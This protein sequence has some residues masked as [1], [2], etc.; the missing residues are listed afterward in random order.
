MKNEKTRNYFAAF[1]RLPSP[2]ARLPIKVANRARATPT[3][4]ALLNNRLYFKVA[5]PLFPWQ[6]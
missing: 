4:K 3:S 6:P 5:T 2:D 1:S